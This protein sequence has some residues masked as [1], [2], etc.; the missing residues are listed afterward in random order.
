MV[1]GSH[2]MI[3]ERVVSGVR[4][5]VPYMDA[6]SALLTQTVPAHNIWEEMTLFST[7]FNVKSWL[8]FC[9]GQ[10][11]CTTGATAQMN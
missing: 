8:A 1:F 11:S 5:L 2:W 10:W 6:G 9:P 4:F 3:T 7:P